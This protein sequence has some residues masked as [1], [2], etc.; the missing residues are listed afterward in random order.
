[1]EVDEPSV[2]RYIEPCAALNVGAPLPK[3]IP[4]LVVEDN[5]IPALDNPAAGGAVAVRKE[6]GP[7]T[8]RAELNVVAPVTAN[9]P[10]AASVPLTE[11]LPVVTETP[12]IVPELLVVYPVMASAVMV[13]FVNVGEFRVGLVRI[14]LV[15]V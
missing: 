6:G 7:V 9:V 14:L 10:L 5:L 11:T 1:M 2:L 3:K 12:Y 13:A 4:K 8:V 15:S